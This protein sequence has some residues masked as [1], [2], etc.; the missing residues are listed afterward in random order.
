MFLGNLLVPPFVLINLLEVRNQMG[1]FGNYPITIPS[2]L[3][4]CPYLQ[5]E[6]RNVERETHYL[7]PEARRP[8]ARVCGEPASLSSLK[9]TSFLGSRWFPW[10][11][12]A[13]RCLN[14]EKIG[15]KST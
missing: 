5:T 14:E 6:G 15:Y 4:K 12:L 2:S 9:R 10:E 13:G 1:L 3:A 11:T 8:Y 7:A